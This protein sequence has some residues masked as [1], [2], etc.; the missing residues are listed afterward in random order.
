MNLTN[1]DHFTFTAHNTMFLSGQTGSGK[2]VLVDKLLERL[3]KASSPQDLKFV[4]LD[5]T[6]VDFWE[7]RKKDFNYISVYIGP[8]FA[9]ECLAVLE[10]M[11]DMSEV[12]I[13]EA[14]KYSLYFVIIEECD[15]AMVD[16]KRFDTAILKINKNAKAANMKLIYSTS[17]PAEN[18]IS[19]NLLRSFD[20]IVAGQLASDEDH[21]HLGVPIIKNREPYSFNIIEND[22]DND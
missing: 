16:Q 10:H 11:A 13:K 19:K 21:K 14:G 22:K 1:S 5:M 18:R 7:L 6:G 15:M 2:S 9:E 3:V 17:V 8:G 20:L 12:R 4:L